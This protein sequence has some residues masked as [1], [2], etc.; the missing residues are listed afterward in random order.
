MAEVSGDSPYGYHPTI[1]LFCLYIGNSRNSC[2]KGDMRSKWDNASKCLKQHLTHYMYSKMISI[3]WMLL[4]FVPQGCQ[5][6]LG[7]Y[8]GD[9]VTPAENAD[10]PSKQSSKV[11]LEPLR[12][13]NTAF[14]ITGYEITMWHFIKVDWLLNVKGFHVVN[15]WTQRVSMLL[16]A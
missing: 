14:V 2:L 6:L 3:L 9:I 11:P 8:E 7:L 10:L 4:F 15:T 12:F 5:L 13:S 1:Q 16:I